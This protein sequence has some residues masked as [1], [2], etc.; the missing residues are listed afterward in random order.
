MVRGGDLAE[1]LMV[2]IVSAQQAALLCNTSGASRPRWRDE[3]GVPPE[4]ADDLSDAHLGGSQLQCSHGIFAY[5]PLALWQR[6]F[7]Q[8]LPRPRRFTR[9]SAWVQLQRL[10]SGRQF[11]QL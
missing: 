10:Y 5:G 6:A 2:P 7:S 1:R 8:N 9:L 11:L 3:R 4:A